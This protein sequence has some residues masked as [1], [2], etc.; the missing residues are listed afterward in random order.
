MPMGQQI[1]LIQTAVRAAGLRTESDDGRY[2]LLLRQYLQSNGQ[3]ATSCKQLN[4]WQIDD[5]LAI[6]EAQGFRMPG[7]AE[8]YFR[9]KAA[10]R[11]G[12]ASFAQQ[13]AI[14]HLAEDIGWADYHLA[15]FIGRMTQQCKRGLDGLTQDEAFKI[16]EGMKAIIG[17]TAGKQ[18]TNLN[19]VKDDFKGVTDGQANQE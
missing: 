1:R 19:Q 15:G 9:R 2:R 12:A 4:N 10:K 11:H 13:A 17:R 3:L 18:Y 7:Q 5:L 14:K 16:I 6:C 8:D